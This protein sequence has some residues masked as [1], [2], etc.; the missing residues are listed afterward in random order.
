MPAQ[1][2][3]IRPSPPGED[4][5]DR[6]RY[7]RTPDTICLLAALTL[8][9]GALTI[10]GVVPGTIQGLVG[11]AVGLLWQAAFSLG[12]V[13]ALIGVLWRDPLT[14]WALEL[15]GRIGLSVTAPAY[16][17][18]LIVYAVDQGF[19]AALVTSVVGAIGVA[20]AWRAWQLTRRL[21][22]FRASVRALRGSRR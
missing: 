10:S 22:E 14:G 20:S 4:M 5:S 3:P 6:M 13:V 12:A 9:G 18:V 19:Q 21:E 8:A 17:S 16:F 1:R 15:S 11:Y 7:G 2:V